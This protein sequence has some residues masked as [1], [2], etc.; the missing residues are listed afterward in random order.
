V[1][2][3]EHQ[4]RQRRF[5]SRVRSVSAQPAP[6]RLRPGKARCTFEVPEKP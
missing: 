2:G 5:P 1:N 4:P 3:R 6:E